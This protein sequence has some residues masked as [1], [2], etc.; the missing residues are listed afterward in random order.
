MKSAMTIDSGVDTPRDLAVLLPAD[1]RARIGEELLEESPTAAAL[2]VL[3]TI[4]NP[5]WHQ[6]IRTYTIDWDGLLGWARTE[7]KST[8]DVR[9]RVEIAASLAGHPGSQAVM[10]YAA[11]ALDEANFE[12][13]MDALRIARVGVSA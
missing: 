4:K 5:G 13:V 6:H 7:F 2:R 11:R 10:L 3:A 1:M 12:A 8:D 9:V